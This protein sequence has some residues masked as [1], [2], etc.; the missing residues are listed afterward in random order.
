MA[1][2]FHGEGREGSQTAR[3][4]WVGEAVGDWRGMEGDWAACRVH[5]AMYQGREHG[6]ARGRR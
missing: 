3:G 2:A 4:Y 5:A 1:A 6:S